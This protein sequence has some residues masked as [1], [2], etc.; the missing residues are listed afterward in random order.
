MS[1]R[2]MNDQ[3]EHLERGLYDG[4]EWKRRN[5]SYSRKRLKKIRHRLMRRWRKDEVPNVKYNGWEW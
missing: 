2:G 1:L 3:I 4:P 5:A